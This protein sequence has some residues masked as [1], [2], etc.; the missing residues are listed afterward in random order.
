MPMFS[1]DFLEGKIHDKPNVVVVHFLG[2]VYEQIVVGL[3]SGK[4]MDFKQEPGEYDATITSVMEIKTGLINAWSVLS[5]W[6][7]FLN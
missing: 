3:I 1:H 7:V 5:P 4:E 6:R 2:Q